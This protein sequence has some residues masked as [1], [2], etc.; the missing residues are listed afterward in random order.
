MH[1]WWQY[2]PLAFLVK[3][4]LPFLLLIV[5]SIT[6]AVIALVRHPVHYKRQIPRRLP[7]VIFPLVYSVAS[8]TSTINIGYR[9]L[10]P[11]L[12]FM[13]VAVSNSWTKADR[14]I[15]HI[16]RYIFRAMGI[17]LCVWQAIAT[18]AITPHYIPY[19]NTLAGGADNG[20]R[21]LADSNTD[22][23][24]TLKALAAYQQQ[25]ETGPVKLSLF[26][27]LDPEAYHVTYTPIAPMQHASPVLP[28]RFNPEPGLYAISA[29]T[30][31][32]VPLPYPATYN[33]FRHREPVA[34]IAHAMHLYDVP[35]APARQWVAQC[36]L[37]VAPLTHDA[38]TEGFG[39]PGIRTIT[40]N[41]EQSWIIPPGDGWY[42]RATPDID[43]LR[44]P[45]A[46]EH[47]ERWP[48]WAQQLA[49][50]NLHLSYEQSQA[51]KLPPF[52][53]WEWAASAI[54][55]AQT[56]P[57]TTLDETITFLGY[58]APARVRVGETI[59]VITYWRVH[60]APTRPLSLMLHLISAEGTSVAVGDGLG[61][62]IDQWRSGD[63][64]INRHQLG[65]PTTTELGEY[66]LLSGAYWLDT[67]QRLKS[68][69][70]ETLELTS[71]RLTP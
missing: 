5:A 68:D 53:I 2:F 4:P 46:G 62:P 16:P 40:F 51:G 55:P 38:I 13:Y 65:I 9:H 18:L 31:D 1:G 25:H 33:W 66:K 12:P 37:P 35:N 63:I 23:G 30:L 32:G 41:C 10:L 11:I 61:V 49:P 29:T 36:S 67:M 6:G 57:E 34:Q 20:W 21:F 28:Q 56:I 64:I 24:Q 26:T 14:F 69:K 59:N 50:D 70:G 7:I 3:T 52:T 43:K 60:N 48:A 42:V 39:V 45:R 47:L 58:D 17:A 19:F 54:T 8:L 71:I 27:F 22:W 44:W 15:K